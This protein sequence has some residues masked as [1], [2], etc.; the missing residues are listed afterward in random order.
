MKTVVRTIMFVLASA[1]LAA[2]VAGP[3]AGPRTASLAGGWGF[4]IDTG[5]GRVTNGRLWL[6]PA[7]AGYTGTL[8]TDRGDNVLPVRSFVVTGA[9]VQMAVESPQGMV[10]FAGALADSARSFTGTVIYHDGQRFSLTATKD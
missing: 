7:E 5:G 10:T 1:C 3:E 8:T 6:T 4:R 9:A 2:C